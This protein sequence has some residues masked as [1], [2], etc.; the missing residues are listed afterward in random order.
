[1]S[2]SAVVH[3]PTV[4][5]ALAKSSTLLF[6]SKSLPAGHKG[7]KG[8][9]VKTF[10][11]YKWYIYISILHIPCMKFDIRLKHK[12]HLQCIEILYIF[13]LRIYISLPVLYQQTVTHWEKQQNDLGIM[14]SECIRLIWVEASCSVFQ[15]QHHC[16][17]GYLPALAWNPP[18]W[19][20]SPFGSPRRC[21]RRCQWTP[22]SSQSHPERSDIF[23]DGNLDLTQRPRRSG[24]KNPGFFVFS[25]KRYDSDDMHWHANDSGKWYDN[26]PR[27]FHQASGSHGRSSH[28]QTVGVHGALVPGDGVP[29]AP[30]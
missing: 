15:H 3:Q 26:S 10:R 22:Q 13:S 24:L 8:L 11:Q 27:G 6:S 18:A 7:P 20:R 25:S 30:T 23:I 5:K 12:M 17:G 2:S 4:G 19:G 16:L 21:P 14:V 28:A 29:E 1:M 9:E